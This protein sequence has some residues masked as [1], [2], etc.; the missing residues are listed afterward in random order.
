MVAWNTLNG[1]VCITCQFEEAFPAGHGVL[2]NSGQKALRSGAMHTRVPQARQ[3]SLS[4]GTSTKKQKIGTCTVLLR[5]AD[6]RQ[7]LLVLSRGGEE[8]DLEARRS[9]LEA[10]TLIEHQHAAC[11]VRDVVTAPRSLES[12]EAAR[13]EVRLQGETLS[14]A[15]KRNHRVEERRVGDGNH[16][17]KAVVLARSLSSPPPPAAHCPFKLRRRRLHNGSRGD[18][19]SFIDGLT[20]SNRRLCHSGRGRW[21]G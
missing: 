19:R 15:V 13:D 17:V 7:P 20:C 18:F 12:I 4:R 5:V 2:Q 10:L 21:F 8:A 16:R 9:N 6:S 1:Q 14:E 11:R 3:Q